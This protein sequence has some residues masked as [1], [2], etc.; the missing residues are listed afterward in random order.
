M[1]LTLPLGRYYLRV[2]DRN[3][4]VPLSTVM[5]LRRLS[6]GTDPLVPKDLSDDTRGGVRHPALRELLEDEK[7][8]AWSLCVRSVNFLEQQIQ[9]Y[10]P[11]T[12]LEFGSGIS[13][14]CLTRFMRDLHGDAERI[15]VCSVEQNRA[16][17]D[18]TSR[19]LKQLKLDRYVKLVNAP[20][21]WKHIV[22]RELSCYEIPDDDMAEIARLRPELVV[23]D[24]P[25]A[26]SGARFGTLP[27][28]REAIASDARVYLDDAFRDGELRIA[29]SWLNLF[30][31]EIEGVLPTKKGLLVGRLRQ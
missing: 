29:K 28:V 14:L 1:S 17:V 23:V 2:V 5:L 18:S 22:D 20:L 24:G 3:K 10:H 26:E 7:L 25:A 9:E 16:V 12:V 31:M 15:L 11:R 19:R 30:G 4:P 6:A 13:T 21:V 27:L 8:G